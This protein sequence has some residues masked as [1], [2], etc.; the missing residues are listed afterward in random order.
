MALTFINN[1]SG[2][3]DFITS[4]RTSG[5]KTGSGAIISENVVLTAAHNIFSAGT[6]SMPGVIDT[7]SVLLVPQRLQDLSSGP[8]GQITSTSF[9]DLNNTYN[10]TGNTSFN[11]ADIS[12][13]IALVDYTANSQLSNGF[14]NGSAAPANLVF[15]QNA[16]NAMSIV[17]TVTVYGYAANPSGTFQL[18]S[19]SGTISSVVS[20]PDGP[21]Y[22]LSSSIN[23]ATGISGGPYI[24]DGTVNGTSFTALGAVH[25]AETTSAHAAPLT[26]DNYASIASALIGDIHVGEISIILDQAAGGNFNGTALNEI[27]H[28]GNGVDTITTGGGSDTIKAGGGD[29]Q[30]TID[31][32]NANLNI[33]GGGGTDYIYVNASD[34]GAATSSF[35]IGS[36]TLTIGSNLVNYTGIQDVKPAGFTP[37]SFDLGNYALVLA[38]AAAAIVFF[39]LS[40]SSSTSATDGEVSLVGQ[41][42]APLVLGALGLTGNED[43]PV[44]PFTIKTSNVVDGALQTHG[45]T[46]VD[47]FTIDFGPDVD[48]TS[49][50]QEQDGNNLLLNYTEAGVGKT[51]TLLGVYTDGS[52][53]EIVGLTFEGR[54]VTVDLADIPEPDPANIVNG[55]SGNDV[56]SGTSGVDIMSGFAG[57][58]RFIG[59]EGADEIDGGAGIDTVD[60]RS[61][62]AGVT[63]NFVT[64]TGSGGHA[65]GDSYAAVERAYGSNFADVMTGDAGNNLFYTY[66]GDDV[67]NAGAGNDFVRGGAGADQMD[68]GAGRDYLDY[69]GSS[70]GVTVN[71]ATGSA[72]GGD[73][74]GDTFVNFEYVLGS[75]S[76]DNITG[77]NANNV[78]SGYSGNDILN[79]GGGNDLLRGGIGADALN[80][81]AGTDTADYRASASAVSVNLTTGLGS[82]GEAQGD[83]YV[84]IERVYGSNAGDTLI[85]DSSINTLYGYGGNDTLNGAG[86]NDLLRGGTGADVLDGGTGIDTADYRSSTS[87]VS[88]NLATGSAT[89]GEAQGDTFVSIER[90]YGSNHADTLTGDSGAN[91]FY[92]YS[93][94]DIINGEGGNDYLRGNAGNDVINGGTGNDFMRGGTGADTLNGGSGTDSIDYRDSS[95]GVT[96]NLGTQTASGG[97]AQGDTLIS[98]ERVY[99]SNHADDLIGSDGNDLIYAYGGNDTIDGGLGADYIKGG[100]GNDTIS[101]VGADTVF[102]EAGNDIFVLAFNAF[103]GSTIRDFAQGDKI[104]VSLV[105]ANGGF[106]E[107]TNLSELLLYASEV[108]SSVVLDFDG[109]S[110]TLSNT[111]ISSLDASD[112]IFGQ[113]NPFP[114][115]PPGPFDPNDPG[116]FG[117]TTPNDDIATLTEAAFMPDY[118]DV[119]I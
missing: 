61:S 44:G 115:F 83:T 39:A 118:V 87:G 11:T 16:G 97:D 51:M 20:T 56:L 6:P 92:G 40:S 32:L 107:I 81:G 55:T 111:T 42:L 25:S 26:L 36:G 19:A 99:A 96:I 64:D 103:D 89:G 18:A 63:V 116:Y 9:N 14:T 77:D 35:T 21:V 68:G 71:L 45:S 70:S 105:A 79:G 27:I 1:A 86:G 69:R 52:A 53:D 110:V 80:G 73:A 48:M 47:R 72:S 101:L 46:T 60:Y 37:P 15:F 12:D 28:G 82:G 113:G 65:H 109:V 62:T 7:T 41:D 114:P 90:A 76:I 17:N 23:T 85:G 31:V 13:D 30:I 98:I 91:L 50:T 5:G 108:G 117:P 78:L 94:N 59:S 57:V 95:A 119:L 43:V 33:D 75:N 84:S 66:G 29:D 102:G 22:N 104:D 74:Q 4:L 67:I 100:S 2:V 3:P 88:V 10:P 49:V 54:T 58:D 106:G 112:F 34:F 38:A 93:G 24:F 8:F